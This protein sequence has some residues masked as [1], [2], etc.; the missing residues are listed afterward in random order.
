MPIYKKK[1]KNG[2]V[3][4]NEKGIELWYFRDYYTDIYGNRK[5]YKSGVIAGK[6]EVQE[7]ERIWLNT[8]KTQEKQNTNIMFTDAFLEWQKFRKQQLKEQTYYNFVNRTNK[9]L[10]EYFIKYRLHAIKINIINLW[11]DILDSFTFS[12]EYKNRIIDDLRDFLEYCR[13]F[14]DFNGKVIARIQNYRVDIPNEKLTD[15]EKNFWCYDEWKE[16]IDVVDDYE[17][18][19]MYN[20]MYY[21]GLRFGEF[22][23]LKITDLDL[24]NK[25]VNVTKSLT[26][27]VKGK[28]FV[29]TTPKTSNSIRTVDLDDE[30]VKLLSDYIKYKKEHCYA[31][32][33]DFYLFGDIKYVAHTTFARR[34]DKYIN[35]LGED[36]KRITPHGFRHSH[37]SLLIDLGCDSRDVA[38]RIGD[39]VETVE[40]TY[41]HMFPKKKK[42]TISKLN[43]LKK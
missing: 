8:P 14:Y 43:N 36:F 9:Y 2:K 42:L 7:A 26:N 17:D 21:T 31:Y 29:I 34:L 30:L 33:E 28:K 12:I 37:V 40:K 19:V 18:S 24:N 39:T 20:F 27:K 15:A 41:Y 6:K 23:A 10:K 3:M 35:K 16:F 11:Y 13:D 4:K 1:D 32:S 25:T 38:E 5:Q 22:D